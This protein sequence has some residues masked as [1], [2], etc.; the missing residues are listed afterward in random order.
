M[1]LKSFL[2]VINKTITF[3][4]NCRKKE[5]DMM[6]EGEKFK[7]AIKKELDSIEKAEK[8]LSKKA[9]I[10]AVSYK[11][12]IEKTIPAGI[13]STLQK[14]FAKAFGIVFEHGIGVIEKGYNKESIAADYEIQN[15]AVDKKGNRQELK[16]LRRSAQKSDLLNMTISTVEGVGLG[17]L[18]IGLP[19]IVI[20]VGMILKGIYEVSLRYG[21]DYDSS[22]EK[23][24][25]LTMMKTALSKGEAW[26][27]LN[28]EVDGMLF[29]S[30]A[31]SDDVLKCEIEDT[32]KVFA[33]DM[34]VFKF[35]QGLPI[36]GVV[37]GVFNPIYYNKIMNYVRLKYH[38]R[39]LL[40][41][42]NTI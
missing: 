19:D 36:V 14:G 5:G 29:T 32:S 1:A 9:Q 33:T 37:G 7:K 10:T 3:E 6:N 11:E 23:Y 13:S 12:K 18:G 15:Y 38:K 20:F 27:T 31:V 28:E 17:A 30:Y 22:P 40:D 41:K 2:K 25:I 16:N 24:F 21:Y 26:N 4:A 39:Y 34:L 35:I 8:K 42:L